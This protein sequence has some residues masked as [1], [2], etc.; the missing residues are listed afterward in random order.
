MRYRLDLWKP[1]AIT[2]LGLALCTA[3]QSPS[4][5]KTQAAPPESPAAASS[6]GIADQIKPNWNLISLSDCTYPVDTDVRLYVH[7]LPDGTITNITYANEHPDNPC[8]QPLY[9]SAK[10]ALLMTRRLILPPGTHYDSIT[11]EFRPSDMQ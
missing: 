6:P 2:M 10:R 3:C 4:Q 8:Y 5:Q 11:F 1:V 7:L 9:A